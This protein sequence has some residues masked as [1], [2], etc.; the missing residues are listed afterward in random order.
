[1]DLGFRLEQVQDFTPTPMT[2]ATEIFATGV[3]PYNQQPVCVARTPEEKHE[4]RSFFFW[5]KP[6]MK[7]V[8]RKSMQRLGLGAMAE[9]LL[10]HRKPTID[11]TP[12]PHITPCGQQMPGKRLAAVYQS[13]GARKKKTA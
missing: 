13:P 3:H 9:R 12:P 4:Q 5:Y 1:K 10:D 8:L 6:E 7:A 2:V 11:V